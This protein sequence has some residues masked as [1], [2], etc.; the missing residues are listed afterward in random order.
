MNSTRVV[1]TQINKWTTVS[2]VL[3]EGTGYR[4]YEIASMNKRKERRW[5]VRHSH[6]EFED[7][8]IEL[9]KQVVETLEKDA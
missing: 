4:Y 1:N 7:E 6:I 8:A 2:T 9:H 3:I 5:I